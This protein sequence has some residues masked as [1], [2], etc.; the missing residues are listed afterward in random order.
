M[1]FRGCQTL[2]AAA[3]LILASVALIQPATAQ[4]NRT[5][6]P[7]PNGLFGVGFIFNG[8]IDDFGFTFNIDQARVEMV[9]IIGRDR[10]MSDYIPESITDVNFTLPS[11][12]CQSAVTQFHSKGYK[13]I[14]A[15][16]LFANCFRWAHT[17]YTDLYFLLLGTSNA[18]AFPRIAQGF[19]RI[20]EGRYI[21][22]LIAGAYTKSNKIGYVTAGATSIPQSRYIA[23]FWSGIKRM[24]SNAALYVW[25]ANGF[26]NVTNLEAA[27]NDLIDRGCDILAT[28][29]NPL[30]VQQ[31]AHRRGALSMFSDGDGRILVGESVLTSIV[32]S[33]V[34]L[35][36]NT[37]RAAMMNALDASFQDIGYAEGAVGVSPFGSSYYSN[38]EARSRVEP[39]IVAEEG[40][41]RARIISGVCNVD[42]WIP[43]VDNVT[44]CMSSSDVLTRWT[45]NL[46]AL[47]NTLPDLFYLGRISVPLA[48]VFARYSD[49][50][51]QA[52]VIISAIVVAILIGITIMI[53]VLFAKESMVIKYSSPPFMYMVNFGAL[54][55]CIAVFIVGG[56][57]PG[58]GACDAALWLTA[59]GVNFTYAAILAK[60]G[61]LWYI[62][63]RAAKLQK[64]TLPNKVLMFAFMIQAF[65]VLI[66]LILGTSLNP[67]ES[68]VVTDPR[69]PPNTVYIYCRTKESS[70]WPV[71][72]VVYQGALAAVGLFFAF[73]TRHLFD[74]LN[75][76]REILLITVNK[77][78]V[79][80]VIILLLYITG[81]TPSALY[82]IEVVGILWFTVVTLAVLYFPKIYHVITGQSM[83]SNENSIAMMGR[84]GT[85][86]PGA[87]S[88]NSKPSF[89]NPSAST[90]PGVSTPASSVV[91]TDSSTGS[92]S[93]AGSPPAK[94]KK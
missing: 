32:Y 47:N 38:E 45:R 86:G 40:R 23:A 77:L 92:G 50:L 52:F 63:N 90:A 14:V 27:A 55:L 44:R 94:R 62:L 34:G 21:S 9:K 70:L 41:L 35:F 81:P 24:N 7:V 65:S 10:V 39:V 51:V 76:S 89:R 25:E 79:G 93:K 12:Q 49:G 91:V 8:K 31:V 83:H 36:V 43:N 6:L 48:E 28:N 5:I 30:T 57:R 85:R 26:D 11:P 67:F 84:T 73:K 54:L 37:T 33:W 4:N 82:A 78:F 20:H 80:I 13:L 56:S 22:G 2:C 53:V 74:E 42:P 19:P 61:R 3:L 17:T 87:T 29:V 16:S 64:V 60:A 71:A 88:S 59:L 66:I 18:T 46:I 69:L 15:P 75:E 68:M 1:N 58:P 72:L